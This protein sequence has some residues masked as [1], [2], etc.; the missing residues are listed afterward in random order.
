[1]T[2]A[3]RQHAACDASRET[4]A[5]GS[6]VRFGG[7][8]AGLTLVTFAA[9][10]TRPAIVVDAA[11]SIVI[12]TA[13]DSHTSLLILLRACSRLLGVLL[14]NEIPVRGAISC[15][16]FFR[17]THQKG[18]FV[19]GRPIVEAYEFEQRQDWI[20]VMV[21]A[22]VLQAVV[23]LPGW[24]RMSKG[25]KETDQELL[26]RLPWTVLVQRCKTIPF[27]EDS[28]DGFAVVPTPS[29]SNVGDVDKY[30]KTCVGKLDRL[31][32][33]APDPRA[34]RKYSASSWMS[35][36]RR[37]WGSFAKT[38]TFPQRILFPSPGL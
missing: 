10:A 12:T 37:D 1:M 11:H 19:A 6:S 32:L 33:L 18:V 26:H 14:Q 15:G 22:S 5:I 9:E 29:G 27:H 24:C 34:Q 28:V 38:P 20:G 4:S 25:K 36:V 23:K 3:R 17:E 2:E 8:C 21:T 35:G 30:L 13:D 31:K 7:Q 16:D